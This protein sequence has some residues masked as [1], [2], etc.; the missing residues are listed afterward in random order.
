MALS[1][2]AATSATNDVLVGEDTKEFTEDES[3][4]S[5]ARKPTDVAVGPAAGPAVLIAV[6]VT[7]SAVPIDVNANAIVA[8]AVSVTLTEVLTAVAVIVE[9]V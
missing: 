9:P 7:E 1:V 8:E 2:L 4:A 5:G 3:V 6:I